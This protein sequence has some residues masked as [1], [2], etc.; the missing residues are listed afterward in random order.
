VVTTGT[1]IS[2]RMGLW[3]E[4]NVTFL[5]D[6]TRLRKFYAYCSYFTDA[7]GYFLSSCLCLAAASFLTR[8][9][10]RPGEA[11]GREMSDSS[12]ERCK[13]RRRRWCRKRGY[14]KIRR[15]V[16]SAQRTNRIRI[17]SKR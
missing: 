5:S 7:K 3:Q 4:A 17:S 15:R 13:R 16:K 6:L 11:A 14:L 10:V 2:D 12:G 8:R 9:E 1:H